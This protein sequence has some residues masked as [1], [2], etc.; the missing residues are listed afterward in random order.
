MKTLIEFDTRTASFQF[1]YEVSLYETNPKNLA[2]IYEVISHYDLRASDCI[3]SREFTQYDSDCTADGVKEA[4]ACNPYTPV[5]VI[6]KMASEPNEILRAI[7][8]GQTK[9]V[10]VMR[11][12]ADDDQIYVVKTLLENKSLPKEIYDII[13]RK[14][15]EGRYDFSAD[16]NKYYDISPR[17]FIEFFNIH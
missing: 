10:D 9:D 8:A 15:I 5:E 1:L 4:L 17:W 7:I 16:N 6:L 13:Y 3:N 2:E 11:F 14:F 12:L